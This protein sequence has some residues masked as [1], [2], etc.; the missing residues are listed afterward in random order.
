MP[1]FLLRAAVAA[2]V[3]MGTGAMAETLSRGTASEPSTLD[4]HVAT[5]NSAAPI[6]YDMFVGLTTFDI[7][8]VVSFFQHRAVHFA[9]MH[10]VSI[11]PTPDE[12]LA[13]HQIRNL[14]ERYPDTVVG[15]S[16]HED[17]N[18]TVPVG[19]GPNLPMPTPGTGPPAA[20]AAGVPPGVVTSTPKGDVVPAVPPMAAGPTGR[21]WARPAMQ[22]ALP[23][24]GK[25]TGVKAVCVQG[26]LPGPGTATP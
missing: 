3:L 11:Y 4:P 14:D 18:D 25:G 13:L 10:C 23:G 7:D 12:K 8:N 22:R 26:G 1:G 21:A 15:W 6:L 20:T 17:P 2:L 16:T 5:G 9:L 24:P 19:T